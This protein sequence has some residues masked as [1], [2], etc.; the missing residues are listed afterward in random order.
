MNMARPA[1]TARCPNT[2]VSLF[3]VYLGLPS[4][5]RFT[6]DGYAFAEMGMQNI[7]FQWLPRTMP[8]S[9]PGTQT[10][11]LELFELAEGEEAQ[12]VSEGSGAVYFS[13][14]TTAASLPYGP[15]L[16]N[17]RPLKT[18]DRYALRV[19]ALSS[20]PSQSYQNNGYSQAVSFKYGH[21]CAAPEDLSMSLPGYLRIFVRMT[22]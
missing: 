6:K 4:I 13:T 2:G 20:D 8:S 17:F 18:G 16:A 12:Q 3:S 10:Y 19:Q 11:Q 7:L 22:L 5:I 14:V 15:G 1:V 21:L 9:G